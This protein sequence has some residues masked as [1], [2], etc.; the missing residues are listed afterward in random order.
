MESDFN[1]VKIDDGDSTTL[2]VTLSGNC[3]LN[4][5]NSI[6]NNDISGFEVYETEKESQESIKNGRYF[7]QKDFE[8]ILVPQKSGKIKFPAINISYFDPEQKQYK[9]AVINGKT[10]TVTGNSKMTGSGS[11][12]DNTKSKPEEVIKIAQINVP[13]SETKTDNDYY[14]LQIK[15]ESVKL[16]LLAVVVLVFIS[17]TIYYIRKYYLKKDN[18][19]SQIYQKLKRAE[20][21]QNVYELFNQMLKYKY[22]ISLKVQTRAQINNNIEDTSLASK[23]IEIMDYMETK[24]YG[25]KDSELNLKDEIEKIYQDYIK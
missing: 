2:T 21:E 5:V 24:K 12:N 10:F 25:N 17:L 9:T 14:S 19:L 8:I 18:K 20:N 13:T 15:K 6:I 4:L 22:N 16:F 3:N 1:E 23:I 7:S 11:R